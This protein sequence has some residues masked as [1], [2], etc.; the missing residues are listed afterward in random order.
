[1]KY[2]N[3]VYRTAIGGGLAFFGGA[4]AVSMMASATRL[5]GAPAWASAGLVFATVG[6][7]IASGSFA[8]R[9]S[10]ERSVPLSELERPLV[11]CVVLGALGFGVLTL[12]VRGILPLFASA[13]AFPA[14]GI[15]LAASLFRLGRALGFCDGRPLL[16]R[17]GFWLVV[18]ACLIGLPWLGAFGLLDPW[19]THYAEVSREMIARRDWISTYWG[20]EGWFKSKPVLSFWLQGLAMLLTGARAGPGQMLVGEPGHFARP[21]WA[22]RLPS[23]ACALIGSYLLYKGVA[24]FAGRRAGLAGGVVLW[25]SAHWIFLSHQAM[26]D[27]PFVGCLSAAAGV[28][29][30][31]L[32]REDTETVRRVSL[33]S[34]ELHAGQ[35]VLAL[36]LLGTL[37][38]V[39]LLL[40]QNLA[41]RLAEAPYGFAWVRDLVSFGSSGNCGLPGHPV[42]ASELPRHAGLQPALQAMG[43]LLLLA[44]LAA[45]IAREERVRRLCFLAAWLF[46]GLS[47]MGKGLAG[48]ALPV[49]AVLTHLAL[50]F[51]VRDILRLELVRGLLAS[52]LLVGPWYLALYARHDRMFFD[53]LV[54]RHMIGRTLEHLH[55]TN[56][57]VDV[58]VRYYVWQLGYAT[59][60]WIGFVPVALLAALGGRG[61]SRAAE[62]EAL[63]VSW[64][65]LAFTLVSCMST[66]FHHY[67][68]PAVPPL[69][70]LV[71]LLIDRMLE[72]SSAALNVAVGVCGTLLLARVGVDLVHPAGP[73]VPYGPARFLQLFTYQ[74]QR[75]WPEHVQFQVTLVVFTVVVSVATALVAWRRVRLPGATLAFGSALAF[76]VWG[77]GRYLPRCA[78]HFGQREIIEDFVRS[79]ASPGEPLIAYQ[80][81][82]KGENF[83]T[84]NRLAIFVS[85]GPQLHAYLESRRAAGERVVHAVAEHGRLSSLRKELEPVESFERLTDVHQSDKFALVRAVLALP[86][87]GSPSEVGKSR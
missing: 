24:A 73:N 25:T 44:P 23:F 71:G 41:L 8:A 63:L 40:S 10:V 17:H 22:V 49:G 78:P 9:R 79:R 75:G 30:L 43:W 6:V 65:V 87:I 35:L 61:S 20:H 57:G 48:I 54:L 14:V 82:W 72:R 15:A 16:E 85:S 29:A 52:V 76:A 33:G 12:S 19:E 28:F 66:K 7:M 81:N 5:R 67:I 47:A 70:M 2:R 13:I 86:V 34:F 64:F 83:Y 45:S 4:L 74:Y 69:A 42:C 80:M 31:G 21:E 62:I 36:L 55:D 38:Q 58:G 84:G 3:L 1:M 77:V 60:P 11:R 26:T 18:V 37:P 46:A 27:M 56:L 39:V 32:S 68:F 53:E 50:R 59:F 51:R